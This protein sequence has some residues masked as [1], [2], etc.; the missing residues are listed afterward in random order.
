MKPVA[1]EL[2]AESSSPAQTQSPPPVGLG[3]VPERLAAARAAIAATGST[4]LV[5]AATGAG[6]SGSILRYL[7]GWMPANSDAFLVLPVDGEPVLVSADRNRARA[8]GM[9]L[10]GAVRVHKTLDAIAALRRELGAI[11]S[12]AR[13]T[14]MGIGDL[15]V[16]R[17]AQ[18]TA[19]LDGF[20][21]VFD[22]SA[23]VDLR[24]R[25]VAIDA[26]A[27]V[28]ATRI[29]D[30]I[31]QHVLTLAGTRGMSGPELMAQAEY[32]GRR[33]GADSAGCWL[34]IGDRPAETYF[35]MFELLDDVPRTAR[36]QIGATVMADGV[37]G[38]VLR[39]GVFGEPDAQLLTMADEL[40]R[41][42]D[43]ALAA[44][45]PGEPITVIGD[46]LEAGIDRL[47]PLS[48]ADDPFRFQSH[49]AMGASYSEPWAAPF[50]DAARDRSRDAGAP[51]LV[52]GQVYEIH[53]NFTHPVL[54]HVCAGDVALVT[55]DGARWLSRTP[56]G[57]L[58]LS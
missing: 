48:R 41:L 38:Q 56:R 6:E 19:A 28:T 2:A 47:T 8:F 55:D 42:Q 10:N 9:R 5:V 46:V 11:R 21:V 53:P 57:I 52:P 35:D 7:L 26:D 22:E 3:R 49:H 12:G 29:A 36:V 15:T 50:T 31:V 44:I 51:V 43:A 27:H 30:A 16:T 58:R 33:L 34:A 54:G 25:R 32:V 18:F 40:V 13:I 17:S 45:R 24:A 4:A 37:F 39:I 14:A 23:V 1:T 20:D